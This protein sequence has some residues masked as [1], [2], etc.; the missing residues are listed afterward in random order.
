M[1]PRRDPAPPPEL[2]GHQ[3]VRILGSG[4]FADVFLY[5]RELPRMPVAVKVLRSAAREQVERFSREVR[6]LAELQH[7]SIVRYVTHGTT[8]EGQPFVVLEWLE[9]EL[10]ARR[11]ARGDLSVPE[12]LVLGKRVAGGL[13]SAHVRGVVHRAASCSSTTSSSRPRSSTS[14]SHGTESPSRR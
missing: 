1:S 10:L 11:L 3:Y 5:E 14:G 6:A 12:A 8:V 4:G 13:A 7:A 9:G 2:P